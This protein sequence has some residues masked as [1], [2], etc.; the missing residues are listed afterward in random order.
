MAE[1]SEITTKKLWAAILV[2]VLGGN[3]T[4]LLNRVSPDMRAD[5]ITGTEARTEHRRIQNELHRIDR[6]QY[7]MDSRMKEREAFDK[8]CEAWM[9]KHERHE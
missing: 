2:A 5:P 9:R 4:G 8:E 3:F 1:P 6:I 7:L